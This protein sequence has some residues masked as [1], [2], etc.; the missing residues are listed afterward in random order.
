M[1]QIHDRELLARLA[2]GGKEGVTGNL[3]STEHG[4]HSE[5]NAAL[6]RGGL[7]DGR[8]RGLRR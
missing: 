4:V 8:Q 3:P 7:S 1:Q 5:R 2:V 6:L